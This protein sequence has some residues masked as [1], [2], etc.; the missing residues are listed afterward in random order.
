MSNNNFFDEI[1]KLTSSALNTFGSSAKHLEES[2]KSCAES[3]I[4]KMDFV[5]KEELV[6]TQ[7]MLAKV[8]EKVESLENKI[9]EL[10]KDK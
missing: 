9:K 10:E 8:M 6:A 5:K 3:M 7:L 2:V 4:A 1:Q